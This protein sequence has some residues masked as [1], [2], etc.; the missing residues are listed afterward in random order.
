MHS[1]EIAEEAISRKKKMSFYYL[2]YDKNL[3]LVRRDDSPTIIEP[4]YIVYQDAR[5]YLIVTGRKESKITHYRID[6]ISSAKMLPEDS[7]P[8]FKIQDAYEYA[9]NKLFMFS[10]KMIKVRIHCK[11]R[12][13]DS[14]VDI[15]GTDLTLIDCDPLHYEF[16]VELNENGILYLAQQFLDAIEIVSPIYIRQ[17]IC[18]RI[19]EAYRLYE[20]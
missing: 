5:P 1:I 14:M 15:F 9:K 17:Q 19:C 12:I 20:S 2:H 16:S 7:D 11:K 6:K 4:R 3:T 13:L 18:N 8:N 10:G